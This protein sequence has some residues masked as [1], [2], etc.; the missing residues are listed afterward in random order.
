MYGFCGENDYGKATCSYN[1]TALPLDDEE[2]L[3]TLQEIC[4][5]ILRGM[6]SLHPSFHYFMINITLWEKVTDVL[7][8]VDISY[9]FVIF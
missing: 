5:D 9:V 4:P 3:E 1:G 2:A 7:V 8:K 6:S